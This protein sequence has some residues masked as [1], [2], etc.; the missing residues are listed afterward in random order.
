MGLVKT[1]RVLVLFRSL[2]KSLSV[3]RMAVDVS[4]PESQAVVRV[5]AR[6]QQFKGSVMW[7]RAQYSS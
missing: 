7:G 5:G 2:C 1:F 6:S 3:G 4:F